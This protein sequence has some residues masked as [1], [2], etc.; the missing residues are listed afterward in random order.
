MRKLLACAVVLAAASGCPDVT[1][2]PGEGSGL[3][4]LDGPTVEFDPANAII[5]FPNNLVIDPMTG[6]VSVPAPACESAVSAAIRT[7]ILDTL[8]GFGTYETGMQVTFTDAVDPASLAGNVIM[9]E[10]ARGSAALDPSQATA[11][12]V[13]VVTG[14]TLR[15]SADACSSPVTINS[16]TIVPKIPLEQKSTYT[17]ALLEGI[18]TADGKP[19]I[20]SVTWALVRQ[21]VDPVTIDASGNIIAESTPF[22]PITQAPLLVQLDGLWKELATGLAFLDGTGAV[23]ARSKL[24]VAWDMTTQTTTDPLDPT[25]ADSPAANLSNR[26][27]L[28]AVS[29]V[30]G[31]T[32]GTRPSAAQVQS[33]L[34][35]ALIA[36]GIATAST[37]AATCTALDCSSIGDVLGGELAISNYQTHTPNPD[38]GGDDVPGAWTDPLMP[39][40]Q[41]GFPDR[42]TPS[43]PPGAIE[44]LMFVPTGNPPATGYPTVVFG[45]GLGSE[46][47]SLIVIAGELAKLGIASAAIDFVDSGS[48]AVRTSSDPTIGC[49]PGFCSGGSGQACYDD[50]PG[51]ACP[52]GQNCEVAPSYETTPQCYASFLSTDLAATR[53]NMR[54]TILDLER[55]VVAIG[56]CGGTEPTASCGDLVVDPA[57]IIYTGISLG[58]ILGSTT[59]S[60]DPQLKGGVLN[61][62]AV[63]WLDILENSSTNEIKCPLVDAL[64]ADGILIGD[65]WNGQDG[66]AAT[67]LCTGD[68][69]KTQPSYQTFSSTARWVLDPADGANYVGTRLPGKKFLLQ[70]V[71]GDLVVPNVATD[72][73]GALVG[74]MPGIADPLNPLDSA[75]LA[76]SA[77]LVAAIGSGANA[78][79]RYPTL[80]DTTASTGMFGNSFQH[81]SLLEPVESLGHCLL[82]PATPCALDSECTNGPGD[83]CVFPGV[84]GTERVQIDA[85]SYLTTLIQ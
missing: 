36:G 26:S 3:P 61:V 56:A 71:V 32:N 30:N 85:I 7:G 44:V 79:L 58:G 67:G 28:G 12:P 68:D 8:D 18:Q 20:P 13:E 65:P 9:Y 48:R 41:P 76:P 39:T 70:E 63:G 84:L 47:E 24:L 38:A 82:A 45:H 21:S 40:L 19:F 83:Q 37:A 80:D 50:P 16:V 77:A 17:V 53:D 81:A 62:A 73:E 49:G 6:K 2:D 15:F 22:D 51:S 14:T 66:S 5:P 29:Q 10:R 57:N 25:V 4:A 78:W 1:T 31:S 75:T 34:Q 35:Q 52:S 42:K 11:V 74:L 23:S 69:W 46:K 55:L 72:N 27:L 43:V 60:I 64:I 33:Y 54:Q 59:V